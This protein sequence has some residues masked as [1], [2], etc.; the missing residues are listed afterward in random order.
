MNKIYLNTKNA[1]DLH[2]SEEKCTTW[3]NNEIDYI[4]LHMTW[5]KDDEMNEDNPYLDFNCRS[6]AFFL[7][8]LQ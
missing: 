5:H 6:A 2:I 3:I 7:V 4:A 1:F 8:R